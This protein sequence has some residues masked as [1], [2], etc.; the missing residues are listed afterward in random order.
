[1]GCDV[2]FQ[3]LNPERQLKFLQPTIASFEKIALP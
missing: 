2:F 3:N 1:M